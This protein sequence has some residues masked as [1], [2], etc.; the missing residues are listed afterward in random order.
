MKNALG[1]LISKLN[2]TE[3]RLS[4]LE[5]RSTETTHTETEREKKE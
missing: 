5:G 4:K 2:T 1:G 3:G